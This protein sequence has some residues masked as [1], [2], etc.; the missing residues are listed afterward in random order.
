MGRLSKQRLKEIRS[1]TQ[2]KYRE[3]RGETLVEGLRA[4]ESALSAGAEI[5][6]VLVTEALR[7]DERLAGRF[8]VLGDIVHV[9]PAAELQELSAVETSQGVLAVVGVERADEE[10]FGS[11]TRMLVFDG[12]R[13]PGNAGALIRSA[14]WFGVDTLVTSQGT[15]DLY[16]PKVV[17]S[18]MG[19]LWDVRH[20]EVRDLA[21][22]LR[23]LREDGF[24]VYGADLQGTP[25]SRWRPTVPSALV[26]GSEAHGLSTR[27]RDEIDERILIPGRSRRGG[28]ESLNVAVAAGILMYEWASTRDA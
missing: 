17:R 10:E 20:G 15:V 7:K 5:R 27:V 2:R 25:V 18:A 14:A 6:D 16:N 19:A 4:V 8:D 28:T 11:S 12:L 21:A 3:R 13:D 1:L 22:T 24:T 9:L 23:Y 26:L